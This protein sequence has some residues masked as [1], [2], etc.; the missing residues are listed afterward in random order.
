MDLRS[1][2][3]LCL[4]CFSTVACADMDCGNQ[5]ISPGDLSS[6]IYTMD[7]IKKYCGEPT[8]TK[9]WN[10]EILTRPHI[11]YPDEFIKK[12]IHYAKWTYNR[13]S[14]TFIEYLLFEDGVLI[15]LK[16]GDYGSD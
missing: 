8:E 11:E 13:G 1:V 3:L 14:N 7:T 12:T 2:M 6:H 15:N 10:K 5:F 9:N 4:F 16:D